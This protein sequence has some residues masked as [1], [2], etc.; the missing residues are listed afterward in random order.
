MTRAARCAVTG[1]LVGL[2]ASLL[3]FCGCD[4]FLANI[5]PIARI[6]ATPLDGESPLV[7]QFDASDS[8]DPDGEIQSYTWTFGDGATGSGVTT[9]HTYVAAVATTRFTATLTVRDDEGA[10][11][12]A[13][14]SI[15]V[16]PSEVP[17]GGGTGEPIARIVVDRIAGT[18]PLTIEFD[19]STSGPGADAI[20]AYN[21]EFGDGETASGAQVS[22]TYRPDATQE[23]TATLFVWTGE[24][25]VDAAEVRI[26]AIVPADLTGEEAPHA[27][28]DM[29]DPLVLYDSPTP[30]T[31]PTL[32]EVTFDPRGSY[33]D[34]GHAIDYYIWDFG[35]GSDWQ[36]ETSD[37]EVT[38]VYQLS[39]PSRT[40]VVR[41]LVYDDQGLEDIGLLNLTLAQPEDEE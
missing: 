21:W 17:G 34:A 2:A 22:H 29:S 5:G 16:R 27:A 15:E 40:F 37:L 26:V 25:A 3:L 41:L 14:Q 4:L 20:A 24:G 11:A 38:H 23:Y 39:V 32:Y 10:T 6:A 36:I 30:T 19:G 28:I 1:S 13:E 12:Q 35:D 31:V 7:V 9:Q 33:A 18:A 8:I